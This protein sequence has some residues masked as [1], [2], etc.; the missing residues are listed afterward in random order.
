[1]SSGVLKMSQANDWRGGGG[2]IRVFIA[3][4]SC[5][6]HSER[7]GGMITNVGPLKH[8]AYHTYHLPEY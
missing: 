2:N 1:M 3:T 7:R 6:L 8:I 4:R 5:M